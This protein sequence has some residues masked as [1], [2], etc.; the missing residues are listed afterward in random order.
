MCRGQVQLSTCN[1]S[2]K[3]ACIPR[4]HANFGTSKFKVQSWR[5]K[6]QTIVRKVTFS[7]PLCLCVTLFFQATHKSFTLFRAHQ[8]QSSEKHADAGDYDEDEGRG[9][10]RHRKRQHGWD[11]DAAD[12]DEDASWVG[13]RDRK[14]QRGWGSSSDESGGKERVAAVKAVNSQYGQ[15]GRDSLKLKPDAAS[16]RSELHTTL[17]NSLAQAAKESAQLLEVVNEASEA[18]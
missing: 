8:D 15:A 10:R 4:D 13:R 6:V 3:L 1:F 11:D 16:T 5:A 9:G 2:F 7:D 17:Q 18:K 12:D 14:R